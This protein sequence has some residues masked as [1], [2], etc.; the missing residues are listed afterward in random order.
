M[1]IY[2]V[3][4]LTVGIVSLLFG[5]ILGLVVRRMRGKY[6]GYLDVSARNTSQIYQLDITTDPSNLR[7]QKFVVFKVRKISDL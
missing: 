5:T 2:T 3:V 6:D 1:E 4:L 7:N